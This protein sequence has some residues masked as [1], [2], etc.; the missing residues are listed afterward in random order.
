MTNIAE[1]DT[2]PSDKLTTIECRLNGLAKTALTKAG[3]FW[4][5]VAVLGQWIFAGYV[6][7]FY[8]GS[9]ISG[10]LQAWNKVLPHG[11]IPGDSIGNFAVGMH[12][13]LAIVIIV[14]GP[15]QL[16]PQ[17]RTRFPRFHR[18]NG[19]VYL[20]TAFVLSIG[21]LFM[22]FTR[23]VIGDGQTRIS[24]NAI[25]IIFCAVM[26]LRY[27]LVRDFKTHRRWALRL[28]LVVGG[29]WFFRIGLMLWLMVNK[30][31]VGFDPKTFEGPFLTF[32]GYAQYLLPLVVLELY[33]RAQDSANTSARMAVAI[34]LF[35]LTLMMA[36]GI[37]AATA[38]M[39]LP[40]L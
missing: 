15:L 9:A 2:S 21:G 26:A 27:A 28:F 17:V 12:L 8:G 23:G 29:V 6:M 18:L 7:V 11:F 4:F 24:I 33:L 39:W 13:L 1:I 32:L 3:Q 31:P 25:L 16:I 30:E 10:D 5:V 14:G 37:F 34:G 35:V 19:R 20:L 22:V 36:G 40:R 38:G